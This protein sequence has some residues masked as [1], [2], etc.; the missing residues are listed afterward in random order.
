LLFCFSSKEALESSLY[1]AQS[2]ISQLDVKREQL[3]GENQ[4]LLLRKEQLQG[5]IQR[6]HV[7]LNAEIEKSARTRDQ[8]QQRLSQLEHDKETSVR[9]HQQAHEDDVERMTRER[10]KIRHELE[11]AREETIRQF[12]KEKDESSNRYEKDKEDLHYELA[13]A[14]TERD[15]YLIEAE[16]EKQK[17]RE[18]FRNIPKLESF[19]A[20]F[21]RSN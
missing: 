2:V 1:E 4:E 9:Q 3:E 8:L 13:T 19:L 17:V 6:L 11:T 20:S 5:E 21:H 15:Q 18:L 14:I 10:D 16:N 12:I 7:E